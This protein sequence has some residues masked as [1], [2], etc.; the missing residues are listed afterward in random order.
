MNLICLWCIFATFPL[1]EGHYLIKWKIDIYFYRPVSQQTQQTVF[2]DT[3]K[4]ICPKTGQHK[5]Y[6]LND[7]QYGFRANH[8][9]ELAIMKLG[10]GSGRIC[11]CSGQHEGT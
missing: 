11:Y 7:S 5:K 10:I 9:T 2:K 3:G 1:K 6:F 8:S 4:I